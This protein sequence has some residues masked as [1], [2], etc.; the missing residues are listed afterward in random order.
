MIHLRL[1]YDDQ[2]D[3]LLNAVRTGRKHLLPV[4]V[5]LRR[6]GNEV[7]LEEVWKYSPP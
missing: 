3:K 6:S 2:W 1:H 4:V 7:N 5:Q